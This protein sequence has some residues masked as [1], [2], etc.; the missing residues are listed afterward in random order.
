MPTPNPGSKPLIKFAR[1]PILP[2]T[3]GE[4]GKGIVKSVLPEHQRQVAIKNNPTLFG[5]D[6]KE[7]FTPEERTQRQAIIKN[8]LL[9]ATKKSSINEAA[10][11]QTTNTST[12]TDSTKL[13]KPPNGWGGYKPPK[14]SLKT[15]S[16]LDS[17]A[18]KIKKDAIL[19]RM[20]SVAKE[21]K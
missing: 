21:T 6:R 3:G 18:K 16:K 14:G 1:H 9:A 4:R 17:E 12:S 20:K 2:G 13:P 19:R 10:K 7:S 11:A 8:R 15:V 5:K